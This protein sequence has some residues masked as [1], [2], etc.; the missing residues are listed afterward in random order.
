MNR[1]T[2]HG[3]RGSYPVHG[4]RY[5]RYGGGTSCFSVE[6]DE[7]LLIVDAGTGIAAL[8][9]QMAGRPEL[10]PITILFTHVHL[11]HIA[12]LPA[13][14]PLRRKDARVTFVVDAKRGW[15]RIL[16]TVVGRPVWPV[17]LPAF[18]ATIRFE[19]LPEEPLHRYGVRIRRHDVPHPQGCLSYRLETPQR[20]IVIATDREHGEPAADRAFQ[21]WCRGAELLVHDAQYTPDE[22]ADRR[23]WGHSTWEEGAAVAAAIGAHR[24][25]LTSHD[26]S[27]S[28]DEVD[29]IVARAQ[30]LFPHTAGAAAEMV[31]D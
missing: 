3:A 21:D 8:G 19:A 15:E 6:T 9:E 7:G 23:G 1:F 16:T 28:D 4:E 29:Q 13:F 2:I 25:I 5:R 11:D 22:F 30:R 17:D 31:V 14:G 24:L 27:R 18:G 10:P 20:T 12:G 26:P